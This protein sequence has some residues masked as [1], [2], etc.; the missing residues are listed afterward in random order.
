M[1]EAGR[2]AA[3]NRPGRAGPR[4]AGHLQLGRRRRTLGRGGE[5]S[6]EERGDRLHDLGDDVEGDHAEDDQGDGAAGARATVGAGLQP[7]AADPTAEVDR[8]HRLESMGWGGNRWAVRDGSSRPMQW[9]PAHRLGHRSTVR[10]RIRRVRR[11]RHTR[12]AGRLVIENSSD[13]LPQ[14]ARVRDR[15]RGY[16][17]QVRSI[18]PGV[19][20]RS[21]QR[22]GKHRQRIGQPG[23]V[24]TEQRI[25]GGHR[26]ARHRRPHQAEA[27]VRRPLPRLAAGPLARFSASSS[28]A[29]SS[30]SASTSSLLRSDALTS[31]S[32]T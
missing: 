2:T 6:P 25:R 27:V 15:G 8:R 19:Q 10:K 12:R 1:R 18:P 13:R 29:R 26:F 22:I 17:R 3:A 9:R 31:P 28:T 21:G 23:A 30:V 7:I 32:V 11:C 14:H 24:G 16:R 20:L 4:R 5:L